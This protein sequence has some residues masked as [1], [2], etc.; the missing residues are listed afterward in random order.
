MARIDVR[1]GKGGDV[2]DAASV[3]EHSNLA[4]RQGN[5]SSRPGRVAQ[6]TANLYDAAG[7][8]TASWFLIGRDGGEAV[9]MAL[10][11]PFRADG[12]NGDV[13]VGTWFLSL[14][15]VLPE[16]WGTGIGGMLLD[17]VI[18]EAKRRG[19]YRIF[20]WTHERQNER[21][22][23]LYRSRSFAPTGRTMHDGEGK[24]IGEWC[25]ECEQP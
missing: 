21:A 25:C 16:R 9:A 14:I 10:V 6:V 11:H 23:R 18:D 2:D 22:H 15:Y 20:L 3:Y 13:I 19:C 17:A 12:G 8:D 24:P 4:R 1:L 7:H 5:W